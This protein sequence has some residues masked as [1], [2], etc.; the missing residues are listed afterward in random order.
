MPAVV[1]RRGR[2]RCDLPTVHGHGHGT[3]VECTDC[4]RQW[5]A[6]HPGNPDYSVWRRVWFRRRRAT[7]AR[8]TRASGGYSPHPTEDLPRRP[9]RSTPPA[10][11][12]VAGG[13]EFT[14]PAPVDLGEPEIIADR[15]DR[16]PPPAPVP[17]G[18]SRT[19]KKGGAQ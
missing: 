2:H 13:V 3:I 7:R 17:S 11:R 16:R 1:V 12:R 18:T 6:H 9:P 5:K 15:R 14:P 8:A 19:V 4:G 10:G